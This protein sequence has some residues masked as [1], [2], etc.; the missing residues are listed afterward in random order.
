[1]HHI[2][3]WGA[4]AERVHGNARAHHV[5]FF[6][7][8]TAIA[9]IARA[10]LSA[11]RAT[12]RRHPT[13]LLGLLSGTAW[14]VSFRGPCVHPR[15]ESPVGRRTLRDQRCTRAES[16]A[17]DRH[18]ARHAWAWLEAL[19]GLQGFR[20]LGGQPEITRDVS[21][22]AGSKAAVRR[23]RSS[24]AAFSRWVSPPLRPAF[25]VPHYLEQ[26]PNCLRCCTRGFCKDHGYPHEL[27]TTRL[28]ARHARE[29]APAAPARPAAARRRRSGTS[30]HA[31]R[32]N[33]P[34]FV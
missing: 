34:A 2:R 8:P 26:K 28:L 1:V 18:K 32:S 9:A 11:R 31:S 10:W 33:P 16:Q 27:W 3:L 12:A 24:L 21:A 5:A 14:P 6:L 19:S 17:R 15:I 20:I 4:N 23:S 7:S 13:R 30:A 22:C 25:F 29:N